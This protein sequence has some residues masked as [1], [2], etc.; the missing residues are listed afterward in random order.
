MEV[1]CTVC[2][3]KEELDKTHKDFQKLAKAETKFFICESCSLKIKAQA[4]STNDL[5]K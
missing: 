5:L 4:A 3:R 2:G 1:I